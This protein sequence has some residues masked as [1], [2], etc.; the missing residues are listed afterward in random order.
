MDRSCFR[1]V[2]LSQ[3]LNLTLPTSP[4][5]PGIMSPLVGLAMVPPIPGANGPSMPIFKSVST[6]VLTTLEATIVI[7]LNPIVMAQFRTEKSLSR[8]ILVLFTASFVIKRASFKARD[9]FPNEFVHKKGD[10]LAVLVIAS[11]F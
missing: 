6:T 5:P 10:L 4:F 11:M 7:P 8:D 3:C 9:E 1:A 2:L